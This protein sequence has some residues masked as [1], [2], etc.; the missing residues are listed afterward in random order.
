M[1]YIELEARRIMQERILSD[2]VDETLDSDKVSE[3][4]RY[5]RNSKVALKRLK[6]EFESSKKELVHYLQ[7]L[8]RG[9]YLFESC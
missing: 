1:L 7:S 3:K 4:E 9:N 8:H 6:S 5:E 2:M